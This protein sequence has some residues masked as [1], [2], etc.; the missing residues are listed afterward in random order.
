MNWRSRKLRMGRLGEQEGPFGAIAFVWEP[1][2]FVEPLGDE[3]VASVYV[4][5]PQPS[6]A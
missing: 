2:S 5:L 3:P 6:G 1:G 4:Y